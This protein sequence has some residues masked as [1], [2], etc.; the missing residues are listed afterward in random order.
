MR[1]ANIIGD[2]PGRDTCRFL[3]SEKRHL[4]G[5]KQA[6]ASNYTSASGNFFL[7]GSGVVGL[8]GIA[9][10]KKGQGRMRRG[11]V[12]F[13]RT[14]VLPILRLFRLL[15]ADTH[16]ADQARTEQQHG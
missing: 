14:I 12:S 7:T 4:A 13:Q 11:P 1:K 16:Q 6:S 2:R 10:M 3:D 8:P 5:N 9:G 15:P